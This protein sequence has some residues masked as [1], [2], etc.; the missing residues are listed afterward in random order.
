MEKLQMNESVFVEAEFVLL[1]AC[2]LLLPSLVYGY[3]TWKRAIN[4]SRLM[5]FG[6][7][8]ILLSGINLILL[9]RLAALARDSPSLLDDKIFTSEVSI[10]LYLLPAIFAGI[11]ANIVSHVLIAHS[12]DAEKSRHAKE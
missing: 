1:I 7:G 6:V 9:R 11:G 3:M 4:R 12:T 10:A 2:S 5:L 8:L